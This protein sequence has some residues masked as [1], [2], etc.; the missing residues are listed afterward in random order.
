[1]S[2]QISISQLKQAVK[3]AESPLSTFESGTDTYIVYGAIQVG[4]VI[5]YTIKKISTPTSVTTIKQAFLPES[6][7][8]SGANGSTANVDLQTDLTN[9]LLLLTDASVTYC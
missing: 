7:R 2:T 1:M 4:S 9:S 5:G 8:I 6:L 3:A